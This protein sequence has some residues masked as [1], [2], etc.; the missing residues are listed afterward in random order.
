MNELVNERT[1][2]VPSMPRAVRNALII[3]TTIALG[4]VL[5]ADLSW[6]ESFGTLLISNGIMGGFGLLIHYDM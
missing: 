2:K 4:I 6:K 5:C 3:G 1:I